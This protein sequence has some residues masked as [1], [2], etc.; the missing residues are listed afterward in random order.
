MSTRRSTPRS[1]TNGKQRRR[2]RDLEKKLP[3]S[4]RTQV[5][6]TRKFNSSR[7]NATA[8]SWCSSRGLR[9]ATKRDV[10]AKYEFI[11]WHGR[12]GSDRGC[13]QRRGEGL[14]LCR[15]A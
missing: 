10:S 13:G 6:V 1:Q 9:K 7:M 12:K 2:V 11:S 14:S 5:L 4:T 3:S 8:S 15:R